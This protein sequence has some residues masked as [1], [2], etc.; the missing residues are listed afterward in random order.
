MVIII[1]IILQDYGELKTEDYIEIITEYGDF[2]YKVSN[3]KIIK[4]T[5]LEELP[6]QKENEKLMIYT[7]YPFSSTGYTEYR[8]VIYADKVWMGV[9]YCQI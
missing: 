2:Y 3:S 5:Q 1:W 6:I 4:D 7:C 8:Y 9:E